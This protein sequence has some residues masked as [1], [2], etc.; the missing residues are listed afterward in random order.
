MATTNLSTEVP[1]NAEVIEV[2][3]LDSVKGN[4]TTYWT[5]PD[6]ISAEEAAKWI[7]PATKIL[8][9]TTIYEA[10]EPGTYLALS[11]KGMDIDTA[12]FD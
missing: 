7:D 3:I 8:Y 11:G 4:Y 1:V 9:A 6:D 10:G 12:I 2:H 5:I